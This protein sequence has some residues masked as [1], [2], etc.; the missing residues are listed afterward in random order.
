MSPA[1]TSGP[2]P[3]HEQLSAALAEL[4]R[5]EL[6]PDAAIPSERELMARTTSPGPPSARRSRA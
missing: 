1:L 3:K 6:A 4:V 5:A 2:V